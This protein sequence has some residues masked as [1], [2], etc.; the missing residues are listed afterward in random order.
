MPTS[1]ARSA[2]ISVPASSITYELLPPT[3]DV[4]G[5]TL[6]IRLGRAST[7]A[8]ASG[9]A[10]L[11]AQ[12]SPLASQPRTRTSAVGK[13]SFQLG[14]GWK[15]ARLSV[16]SAATSTNGWPSR[17]DSQAVKLAASPVVDHSST[18]RPLALGGPCSERA[19]S[20]VMVPTAC[21][22]CGGAP[23][24][25]AAGSAA[26]LPSAPPPHPDN[27]ATHAHSTALQRRHRSRPIVVSSRPFRASF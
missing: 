5:F 7:R 21:S 24:S 14:P 20:N 8:S 18:M 12:L 6:G 11:S 17:G 4:L 19:T 22:T 10:L 23:S 2:A 25:G 1:V 3:V 16:T 9:S 26:P 13:S 27:K 15:T